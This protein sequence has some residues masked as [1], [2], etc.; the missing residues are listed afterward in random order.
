MLS[1]ELS[2]AIQQDR[3]RVMRHALSA[4]RQLADACRER[5]LVARIRGALRHE[6]PGSHPTPRVPA[7]RA[8]LRPSR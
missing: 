2:K 4:R 5:G 8:D 1:H 7:G 3:E 6:A